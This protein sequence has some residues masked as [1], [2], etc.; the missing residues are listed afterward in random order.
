MY[1]PA[2]ALRSTAVERESFD[3]MGA[4]PRALLDARAR[5]ATTREPVAVMAIAADIPVEADPSP[6]PDLTIF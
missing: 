6:A 4:V 2:A 1:H 5:R 3:D